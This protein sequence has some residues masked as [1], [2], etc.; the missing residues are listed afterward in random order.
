MSQIGKPE[1]V[2][3]DRVIALFKNEMGY[4]LALR[5][6]NRVKGNRTPWQAF[7][8]ES[9]A[10]FNFERYCSAQNKCRC[11]SAT[12]LPKTAILQFTDKQYERIVSFHG[13]A[14]QPANKTPDQF[15]LF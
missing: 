8:A 11:K 12:A 14:K 9:N 10:G 3:Q 15:D 7:G 4:R 6:A 13:K 5:T 1:R 2:T